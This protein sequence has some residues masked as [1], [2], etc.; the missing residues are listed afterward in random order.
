MSIRRKEAQLLLHFV[1]I[2]NMIRAVFPCGL[3]LGALAKK[4]KN[5]CGILPLTL[6]TIRVTSA[7]PKKM[8]GR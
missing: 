4:K 5:I 1:F 7:R 3:Q 8:F 6:K 2:D